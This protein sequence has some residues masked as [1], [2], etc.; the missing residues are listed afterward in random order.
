MGTINWSPISTKNTLIGMLSQKDTNK[1][2]GV[3]HVLLYFLP[4]AS[5]YGRWSSSIYDVLYMYSTNAND[6]LIRIKSNE[7]E[8]KLKDYL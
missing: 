6:N 7:I 4:I 2:A 5:T 1:G 8:I 3:L